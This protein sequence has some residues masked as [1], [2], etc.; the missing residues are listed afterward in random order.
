MLSGKSGAA[1]VK[2]GGS[3]TAKLHTVHRTYVFFF[4]FGV[5]Y[6][7]YLDLV[8]LYLGRTNACAEYI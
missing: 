7:L 5:L 2:D 4:F 6:F 1:L 8:D 3:G